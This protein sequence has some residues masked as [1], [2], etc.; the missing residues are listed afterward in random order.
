MLFVGFKF[1]QPPGYGAPA[2]WFRVLNSWSSRWRDGG[3][4][5]LHESIVTS[6]ET[7]DLHIIH[8][9]NRIAEAANEV[10]P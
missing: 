2:W 5:W 10:R 3:L 4:C 9:W 7:D 8:G 6:P 1:M